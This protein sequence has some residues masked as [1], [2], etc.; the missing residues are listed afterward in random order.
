M[1]I[2]DETNCANSIQSFVC[3]TLTPQSGKIQRYTI[4][5]LVSLATNFDL[6]DNSLKKQ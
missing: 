5:S 6:L 3:K 4:S 2:N 1:F